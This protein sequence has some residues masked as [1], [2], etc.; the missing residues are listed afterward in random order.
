MKLVS[1]VHQLETGIGLVE[2]NGI[3]DLRPLAAEIGGSLKELIEQDKLTSLAEREL[4]DLPLLNFADLTLL[5]VIP[6]PGKV[7]C[8][9]INYARH[10]EETGMPKPSHPMVFTRFADAQ[11][12]HEQPL[13][14]PRVSTRFDY[15][16]ELAVIIGKPARYV[17]ANEALDYVAGY[18]C[19]NDGSVRDWQMHT[20]QFTPGKN[21]PASGAFGPW[22][23]TADEIPDPARLQLVTR[24]NG[25]V[26]QNS[27]TDDLLFDVPALIEYLSACAQL[28]PGDVIVT[29]TPGGAGAFRDPKVWMK[30]GD[31]VEVEIS[32]IGILSNPVVEE[33]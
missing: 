8:I 27:P 25:E 18:S 16:G 7:F 6:D 33:E 29:G 2:D 17:K 5:P 11:V 10:I 23:V 28:N 9:G 3:R 14:R 15:E 26:M 32:G 22:L 1:F 31:R 19:F 12:G 4:S 20:S 21:F 24:L 13:V 30:P